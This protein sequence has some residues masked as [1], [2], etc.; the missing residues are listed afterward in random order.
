MC[1]N[2]YSTKGRSGFSLF[3]WACSATI[4]KVRACCFLSVL[5]S[6]WPL[7]V[8]AAHIQ[9]SRGLPA[10]SQWVSRMTLTLGDIGS[11]LRAAA[12]FPW[13][14]SIEPC[15]PFIQVTDSHRSLKQ[16][17]GRIPESTR[18]VAIEA[19]G[20]GAAARYL[21]SSVSV[22]TRSRC[23]SPRSSLIFGAECITPHSTAILRRRRKTRSE[24]LMLE[25]C[26]SSL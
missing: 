9:P 22:I 6:T 10:R 20:S 12:V 17:S 16:S 11:T 1:R 3:F 18:I 24:E 26:K 21:A 4:L 13:V 8:G 19:S 5:G 14:T 23:F 25:A 7:P 2:E 15:L